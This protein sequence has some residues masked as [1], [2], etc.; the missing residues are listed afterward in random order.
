M[1]AATGALVQ[2]APSTPRRPAY[3]GDHVTV[4]TH[5]DDVHARRSECYT[6]ILVT[7]VLR[8]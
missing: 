7:D 2:G 5:D 3:R 1:R 6:Y 4:T 8:S